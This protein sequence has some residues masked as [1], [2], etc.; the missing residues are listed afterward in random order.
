MLCRGVLILV[1]GE[2]QRHGLQPLRI[3]RALRRAA[4]AHADDMAAH[5]QMSH[6]SS[7]GTDWDRRVS[8]YF[9]GDHIG[10]NVAEG[11]M[12]PRKV[13]YAWM[14]SAPHRHNILRE[15]YRLTGIGWTGNYWCQDFGAW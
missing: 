5:D 13:F 8:R 2:R 10:E 15:E 6:S 4:Q 9:G 7:D 11:F 14:N 12:D 3:N 1:N